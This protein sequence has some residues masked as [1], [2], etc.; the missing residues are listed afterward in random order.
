MRSALGRVAAAVVAIGL[1]L[2][3]AGYRASVEDRG[4]GRPHTEAEQSARGGARQSA[5]P[6]PCSEV[7][8]GVADN[9]DGY[10]HDF[11]SWRDIVVEDGQ[12]DYAAHTWTL[13]HW[14]GKRQVLGYALEEDSDIWNTM[15]CA[16]A[17]SRY[18]G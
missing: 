18:S 11:D 3:A 2:G 4:A 1:V 15:P 13:T 7:A 17:N 8:F 6:S 5:G 12:L 14:N 16:A 10:G 9:T